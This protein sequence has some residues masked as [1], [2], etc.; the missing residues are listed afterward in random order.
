MT[1]SPIKAQQRRET[2]TSLLSFLLFSDLHTF[3]SNPL[4]ACC[5]HDPLTITILVRPF[6]PRASHFI[7][8]VV[9]HSPSMEKDPQVVSSLNWE[10]ITFCRR[11]LMLLNWKWIFNTF[12]LWLRVSFS[13]HHSDRNLIKNWWPHEIHPLRSVTNSI[14]DTQQKK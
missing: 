7:V 13:Y 1:S 2:M 11:I 9:H 12:S 14:R 3:I 4:L 8:F 5:M 6:L 10:F